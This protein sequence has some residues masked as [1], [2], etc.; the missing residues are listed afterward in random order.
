MGFYSASLSPCLESS[1]ASVG[2]INTYAYVEG[3]PVSLVDPTGE[4][5]LLGAAAGVGLNLGAQV[6]TC[7]LLGGDLMTCLKCVDM[8]DVALSGVAGAMGVSTF[9]VAKDLVKVGRSPDLNLLAKQKAATAA[10]KGATP[11]VS[12]CDEDECKKYNLMY[13]ISAIF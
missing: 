9:K 12:V 3:N 13:A 8:L 11:P 5:A 1:I 2:G 10:A 6:G 4:I 7:I